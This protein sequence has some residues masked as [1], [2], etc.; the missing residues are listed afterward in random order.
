[1]TT[2][3]MYSPAEQT[4]TDAYLQQIGRTP[5]LTFDDEQ[6]LSRAARTGDQDARDQLITSNLLLV[7]SIAKTYLKRG[8]PLDDLIQFGTIGLMRAVEKFDPDRGLKFS[9][10]ATWWIK[11]AIT[12]AVADYGRAIRLPVHMSER[13]T[14]IRKL[15]AREPD[16][17]DAELARALGLTREQFDRTMA[18][19]GDC[20]SLNWPLEWDDGGEAR[21]WA[22]YLAADQPGIDEQATQRMMAEAVRALLGT[23]DDR[24]RR[25]LILRYGLDGSE[26]QTLEQIGKVF[27]CTRENVRQIERKALQHL[28]QPDVGGALRGY[29]S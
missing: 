10:Y 28:R 26:P 1:M 20:L 12:R 3:N 11:Q 22:D 5:L 16:M 23:L 24:A 18:A 19:Q 6:R 9:T 14:A 13:I 27:G 17:T 15:Q 4:A 25:I 21:E 29:V 7:V 2:L 8:F